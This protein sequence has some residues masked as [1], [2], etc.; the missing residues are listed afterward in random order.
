MNE[1]RRTLGHLSRRVWDEHGAGY[2][3]Q[4]DRAACEL[5]G[6]DRGEWKVRGGGGCADV[7]GVLVERRV[8]DECHR[9]KDDVTVSTTEWGLVNEDQPS[10]G[11]DEERIE[12]QRTWTRTGSDREPAERGV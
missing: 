4:H 3:G 8:A 12:I 9:G 11:R 10:V 2:G 7:R 6:E 1:R 5:T